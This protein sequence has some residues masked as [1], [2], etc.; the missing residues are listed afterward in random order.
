[1][2]VVVVVVKVTVVVVVVHTKTSS[3]PHKP[4][5]RPVRIVAK[6]TISFVTSVRLSASTNPTGWIYAKTD[7]GNLEENLSRQSKFS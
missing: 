1:V 4:T 3:W 2:T 6:S 5:F 7:T